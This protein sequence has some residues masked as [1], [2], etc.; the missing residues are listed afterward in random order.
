MFGKLE[1]GATLWDRTDG[2]HCTQEQPETQ[3]SHHCD[4]NYVRLYG[5]P[6]VSKL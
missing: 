6:F 2:T 5:V 4:A 1:G 3:L